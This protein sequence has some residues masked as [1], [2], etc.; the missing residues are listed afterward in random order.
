MEKNPTPRPSPVKWFFDLVGI[1]GFSLAVPTGLYICGVRGPALFFEKSLG[2]FG[3]P[4]T[5]LLAFLALT[6]T[7][8]LFGSARRALPVMSGILAGFAC[9]ASVFDFPFVTFVRAA[10]ARFPAFAEPGPAFFA[11]IAAIAAGSLLG[12]FKSGRTSVK[13]L[14]PVIVAIAVLVA[15]AG[16]RPFPPVDADKLSVEAAFREISRVLGYDYRNPETEREVRKVLE[17]KEKSLAEKEKT[18]AE[19]TARLEKA[20]ED[21]TALEKAAGDAKRLGGELDAAR[22][23]LAELKGKVDEATP[24]LVGGS[25]DKAVQSTDPA[26]RDF[27][28][29]IAKS[30][31]GAFDDPQGSRRPTGAGLRQVALI[32]GAISSSWKYVS[33]PGVNWTEYVSPAR[34]TLALGLAGDCDDF[35]V[36]VA[37]CVQA[38]GGKV[39][40]MHGY[41]ARGGHAWAELWIGDEAASIAASGALS[42]VVGR[43]AASI[44]FDRDGSGGRWLVLDWRLGEFSIKADRMEVGWSGVP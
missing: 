36:L 21:R 38:V 41:D 2:P 35:A 28:V 24:L 39:R 40:I 14:S 29:G 20:E 26:I 18:I 37:S 17:D 19:L 23:A 33:D 34:R 25:Y 16:I 8:M 5:L 9:F 10:A 7:W 22:K 31:P 12:Q 4:A 1:I 42:R 30:S 27:A 6:F 44:A 11:G 43:T 15:L 13:T 32:H 3:T